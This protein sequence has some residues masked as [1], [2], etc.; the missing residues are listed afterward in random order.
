[1]Q[2]LIHA[3]VERWRTMML[4]LV[5]LFVAGF[6]SYL[7]IPKEAA[8]D[9]TI[10]YI[11]V[12]MTL[13]GISP[14]DAERLLLRPMEKQLQ[15]IEGV[16]E[17]T[18]QAVE[19]LASVTLEFDAGFDPDR[20]LQD[21]RNQVDEAKPDLPEETDEPNV[22]E[23]NFSQF[24]I[25]NVLLSGDVEE[26]ILVRLARDLRDKIETLS[27]VLEARLAGDREE[28]LEILIEPL[29]LEGYRIP[30]AEVFSRVDNNN[31]L[32]AAGEMDTGQGRFPLKLP[33]L[34]ESAQDL[35]NIP[36][37][38]DNGTVTTLSD[39]TEVRRSFKDVQNYARLNGQRAVALQV[40]K[41]AGE[42]IIETVEAVRAL[43]EEERRFWPPG[44]EVRYTN[45]ESAVI[46]DRVTDLQNNVILAV[47]LVAAV[48]YT[49]MGARSAS[50]VAIAIPGAFLFG[51][52]SLYLMG[53]TMNIV[54][55]FAL[56]LSIGMLVDS[57]IVVSEYADRLMLEGVSAREAYP[58]AAT[59]MAWPII[60]STATTLVVFMPLLFWPDVT[61]EFMKYLP[62]TLILTL[63]GSLLMALLFLPMLGVRFGRARQNVSSSVH[64]KGE[65]D[66]F[67]PLTRRYVRW[68]EWV[69]DRPRATMGT[70]AGLVAVLIALF[71]VFGAGV[72]FFP[73]IEPENARVYVKSR[74]NL[75]VEERDL[76]VRR[77][78][79]AIRDV[80]GIRYRFATAGK[81]PLRSD[82][83]EDIIGELNLE[84]THWE[85]RPAADAILAQIR[86]LG[87]RV[88]GVVMESVKQEAGPPVGK[89][90]QIEFTSRFAEALEPSLKQVRAGMEAV[91][92]FINITDER[93]IPSIEWKLDVNREK[94][95]QFDISVAEIG[96]VVKMVSN[97]II[98]STYRPDD[99]DD[100]LDVVVRFPEE[101]RHISQLDRLRVYTP[102]GLVPIGNF[103]EREAQQRVST[104]RRVDGRRSM[105]L[106][107]DLEPGLNAEAKLG[108]LRAWMERQGTLDP[109][110]NIRFRG[111]KEEQQE[112]MA[113]LGQ[114][115]AIA[116]FMMILI[117]VTQFNSFYAMLVIMSA[118]VFSTGGVFLGLLLTGTA[119]GIVMCGV[120]I[121]SLA[122]IVVNNNII[123]I[124]AYRLLREQ[125]MAAREALLHT[126][127]QRLRPIL[128]TAGTTVLGLLPMV[129]E[130][131]LNFVE[132][133]VTAGAPSAQWWEQLSTA[134]AG[135]LTFATILTLFFTPC[136]LL[137]RAAKDA[138][139]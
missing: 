48:I 49:I 135:G 137:L 110:V 139:Q 9:I 138:G 125:G 121:I 108:E 126:G 27:P 37:K 111:E 53:F 91:G 89:A 115:F 2:T 61:G 39:I 123:F 87:E 64:G 129:F 33:G 74:G 73:D 86:R 72:E 45:D 114:A 60:A 68:L 21:V 23:I 54:V 88:P 44:I 119:F 90:V 128:L 18:S 6:G 57:A 117:L 62:I 66:V 96:Q 7:A 12:S 34:I 127:A 22:V 104:L 35:R 113:F 85:D 99:A 56:I 106:R 107:A 80:P 76:L 77:V 14:E 83:P 58:R 50:L 94:A 59:R 109:R 75:S 32:I 70:I 47:M 92:G 19:G 116:L 81:I 31:L 55:L 25:I 79:A 42:N 67:E 11:Y 95:G 41:R 52:L 46:R 29:V 97:G 17:M 101:D 130:L 134:I 100:E 112:T 63:S 8:P 30:P 105:Y 1:M 5:F 131:N 102:A 16:K 15:A 133:D 24:P 69:L 36:I 65:A 43:V 118:V 78:E 20:A 4:L 103:I 120:G 13:E 40:S 132:L 136:M 98:V 3:V 10:P 28:M 38:V 71:G 93:P 26:R 122:G 51:V 124:D 82:T 84:F